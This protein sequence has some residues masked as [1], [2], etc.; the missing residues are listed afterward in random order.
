[1]SVLARLLLCALF[2][3][4]LNAASVQAENLRLI[5]GQPALKAPDPLAES[6]GLLPAG[7]VVDAQKRQGDWVRVKSEQIDGWVR[8]QALARIEGD[9]SA[10]S[11]ILGFFKPGQNVMGA[12]RALPAPRPAAHA[13][14]L[15]IGH[16]GTHAPALPG[17]A[18]DA[19][20]AVLMARGLGVPEEQT[21]VLADVRLDLAGLRAAFDALEAKLLPN[22]EVFIYFSGHG[23][24]FKPADGRCGEALLAADGQALGGDELA[25]RLAR[26]GQRSARLL[27]FID[28]GRGG[29]SDLPAGPELRA[30]YQPSGVE[31]AVDA[32]DTPFIQAG[33]AE[34][35]N[36]LLVS[37]AA[38]AA[39]FDDADQG[40]LATR[41]WLDCLTASAA[42]Q[43]R[44]GGLA[45]REIELCAQPLL[46]TLAA[47]SGQRPRWQVTG[48]GARVLRLIDSGPPD[49]AA[50]LADV[51]ASRDARRQVTLSTDRPS[52]RIGQDR[53]LLSVT[54]NQPG[55]LY[56]LRVDA[57]G[58]GLEVLFPN[59]RDEAN[60]VTAGLPI[61]LPRPWWSIRPAG[62]AG[63]DWLLAVVS[64]APRDFGRL[65]RLSE[66]SFVTLSAQQGQADQI[67]AQ[68]VNSANAGLPSCQPTAK[69]NLVS[70]CSDAYGAALIRIEETP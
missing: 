1:M 66:R 7:L 61:N 4:S 63:H 52:Y 8:V 32:A 58:Q 41:A 31:C 24:R 11:T 26:I 2:C 27:V 70:E 39:A 12:P 56:V 35:A 16:Y 55:Y 60:L 20:S 13:L 23:T 28:A 46:A 37:P 68:A 49:L 62:P 33:G 45:A 6:L 15:T 18:R 50:L 9:S 67:Q 19:D 14:I 34:H 36:L 51:H 25:R 17:V 64:D 38:G 44:S 21:A 5:R 47:P 65:G 54:S 42:D 59:G 69:R 30:K 3:L 29:V 43:D 53:L 22:D 57:S 10:W 48:N 40:G